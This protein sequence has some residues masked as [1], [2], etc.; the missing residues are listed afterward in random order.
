[1]SDNII[2]LADRIKEISY[3][4]NKKDK[5]HYNA[6]HIYVVSHDSRNITFK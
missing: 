4:I 1:M 3:T 5:Y 6:K 2:R